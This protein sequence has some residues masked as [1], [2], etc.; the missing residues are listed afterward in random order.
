MSQHDPIACTPKNGNYYRIKFKKEKEEAA[1][2]T[3]KIVERTETFVCETCKHFKVAENYLLFAKQKNEYF[4][5]R[6]CNDC[7]IT[8]IEV[9]EGQPIE[10]FFKK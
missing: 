6:T 4:D 2:Q 5:H 8:E 1:L 10:P 3:N 9:N 7:T